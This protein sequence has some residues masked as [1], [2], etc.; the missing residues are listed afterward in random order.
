MSGG[1]EETLPLAAV[2]HIHAIVRWR[3]RPQVQRRWHFELRGGATRRG[4]SENYASPADPPSSRLATA[5]PPLNSDQLSSRLATARGRRSTRINSA[6]VSRRPGAAAQ[7]E[8]R[9]RRLASGPF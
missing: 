5:R 7:L 4:L 1:S 8:Q 3:P 9:G 2:I 6:L